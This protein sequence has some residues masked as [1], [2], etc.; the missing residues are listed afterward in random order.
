MKTSVEKSDR[1]G[2][3]TRSEWRILAVNPEGVIHITNRVG[4]INIEGGAEDSC[5]LNTRL[6]VSGDDPEAAASLLDRLG[7]DVTE[8][9]EGIFLTGA[10]PAELAHSGLGHRIDMNIVLP[11]RSKL[12]LRHADGD[13]SVT[14]LKGDLIIRHEV[15]NITCKQISGDME[16]MLEDG[17]VI[18]DRIEG[19]VL[20][21]DLEDGNVR[22]MHMRGTAN[23]RV[24]EGNVALAYG[25]EVSDT[26]SV[27]VTTEV[28][29]IHLTTPGNMLP[30]DRSGAQTTQGEG[31]R[32]KSAVK[33]GKVNHVIKLKAEEGDVKVTPRD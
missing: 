24:E 3:L 33:Q 19:G 9:E 25:P 12:I 5:L 29:N 26:C 10:A 20:S 30:E 14:G 16:I 1:D 6:Q 8:S 28:G 15:G 2:N 32:W 31:A 11:E 22:G 21:I 4:R 7:V 13:I 27:Y 18:L 17:N 23:V